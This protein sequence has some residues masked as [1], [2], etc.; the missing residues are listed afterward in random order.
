MPVSGPAQIVTACSQE[1]I[2]NLREEVRRG[3]SV[4]HASEPAHLSLLPAPCSLLPWLG[5]QGEMDSWDQGLAMKTE[6]Q[7]KKRE[8]MFPGVEL[9]V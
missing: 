2:P 1:A 5:F 9:G 6:N 8:V 7:Q 4:Q 3:G